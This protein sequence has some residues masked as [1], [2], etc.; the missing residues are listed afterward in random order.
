MTDPQPAILSDNP[1]HARF[2][3]FS[4][5]SREGL[6]QCLQEL[7]DLA[8]GDSLVVGIG[9]SLVKALDAS[10]DGLRS[11]PAMTLPALD[12]PATP[13]AMWCW[14]RGDDR[15]ELF[16]QSRLIESLLQPAFV[17]SGCV[18]SFKYDCN[19]DLSG[20]EDGTENPEGDQAIAAAIVNGKGTG[21]DGSSFVAVQQ[22]LHDFDTF[23]SMSDDEQDDCIGRHIAD[24]EEYDAPVSAH[25]K[26]SAQEDFEPEAFMLRHPM[27]WAEDTHGGLMF[28]AFGHSFNAFE[29]V[30]NRMVGKDDGVQDALF[31]FTHPISGSYFWCPPMKDGVL[32][33]SALGV[34]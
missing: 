7:R 3:T 14:L 28:I 20:Y 15:G 9:L 2:L 11:F 1:Q 32:D 27:P 6:G 18:D 17:M 13:A 24:N 8:D 25:V 5:Q 12:I 10:I 16:H 30:L 22:W 31:S 33:L 23:Y 29:A 26:R 19:R 21:L 4:L 34:D